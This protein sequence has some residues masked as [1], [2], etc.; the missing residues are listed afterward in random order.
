MVKCLPL[1]SSN[2][3]RIVNITLN[4]HITLYLTIAG[5]RALVSYDGQPNVLRLRRYGTPLP[6]MP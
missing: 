5:H 3:I 4:K 6:G 1:H 2:G